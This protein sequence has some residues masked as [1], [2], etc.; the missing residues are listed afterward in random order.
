MQVALAY[1]C[2]S[3]LIMY[4]ASRNRSLTVEAVP[5]SYCIPSVHACAGKR[6]QGNKKVRRQEGISFGGKTDG[7]RTGGECKRRSMWRKSKMHAAILSIPECSGAVL[8]RR[9]DNI[10]AHACD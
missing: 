9:A 4:T 10:E 7:R 6:V 8:G 1:T 5:R 3:C 2:C